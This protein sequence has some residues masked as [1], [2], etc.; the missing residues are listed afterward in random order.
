MRVNEIFVV[1][2]IFSKLLRPLAGSIIEPLMK[3]FIVIISL[4]VF[5]QGQPRFLDVFKHRSLV[6]PFYLQLAPK[7]FTR[8]V[9]PALFLFTHALRYA[10]QFETSPKI[11]RRV[12]N[13]P[14]AVKQ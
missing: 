4:N 11:V 7:T 3:S 12:L 8:C 6:Y 5:E 2:N 1:H 13:S 14:V 9:I 10:K